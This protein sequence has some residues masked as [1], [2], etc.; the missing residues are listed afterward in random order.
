MKHPLLSIII[1]VHNSAKTLAKCLQSIVGQPAAKKIE[2]LCIND[3]S[4]DQSN[5]VAAK[6]PV[7][8][9]TSSNNGVGPARNT[10]I[11]HANGQYLWFVDADDYLMPEVIDDR[12]ITQ[13]QTH[14]ADILVV[15]VEKRFDNEKRIQ[16]HNARQKIYHLRTDPTTK[17]IFNTNILNS[18]WNKLYA[19]DTLA[20]HQIFFPAF[21]AGEDAIFNYQFFLAADTIMTIPTVMYVFNIFSSSSSKFYWK[22]D[23]LT[24]TQLLV[25]KLQSLHTQTYIVDDGL[26]FKTIIDTVIGNEANILNQDAGKLSYC[27][28]RQQLRQPMFCHLL[29]QCKAARTRTDRA[30]RLKYWISKSAWRSYLYIQYHLTKR[31]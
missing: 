15:G 23:Q 16:I 22:K 28:Y 18:P 24:A 8:W 11:K 13:L 12:F 3:H 21:S 6:Y 29:K 5:Q 20:Q 31:G 26:L 2:I 7:Q 14:P 10:G 1:P 19:K 30:Y 9:L 25:T 4:T 17:D 27:E